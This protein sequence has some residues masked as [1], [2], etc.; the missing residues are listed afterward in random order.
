MALPGFC[1]DC[2]HSRAGLQNPVSPE[3]TGNDDTE[4]VKEPYPHVGPETVTVRGSENNYPD[5]IVSGFH[6]NKRAGT[7]RVGVIAKYTPEQ[8]GG[9]PVVADTTAVSYPL[10]QFVVV[11]MSWFICNENQRR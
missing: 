3:E 5:H 1:P 2:E 10:V 8:S 7:D 4:V 9:N 6:W 11:R